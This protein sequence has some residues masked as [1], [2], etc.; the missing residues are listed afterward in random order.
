MVLHV[1]DQGSLG[2]CKVRALHSLEGLRV[3][4]GN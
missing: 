1:H 3:D 4:K 2:K